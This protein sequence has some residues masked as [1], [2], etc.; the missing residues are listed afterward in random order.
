[1]DYL[2]FIS[3]VEQGMNVL[4]EDNVRAHLHTTVKN[5]GRERR[6][7]TVVKQGVNISPTIY[8]EEFY[9]QYKKGKPLEKIVERLEEFYMEVKMEDSWEGDFVQ[10]Y[11]K[12]RELIVFKLINTAKNRELLKT[13][14]H[15]QY[16]DLSI[17][18]YV[19]L[20]V[21]QG[22]SATMMV[23]DTFLNKWKVGL[24]EIYRQA[25]RNVKV[26]LPATFSGMR[27]VIDA[28]ICEEDAGGMEANPLNVNE[29]MTDD[30]MYV[31]S[32]RLRSFGAAA[33]AYEHI[34]E[35]IGVKLEENFY[36]L[37]SSVHELIILPDSR[38]LIREELDEMIAEI[39]A[40][41]V[42]AEE[43]L[44]N[45]AYYYDRKTKKLTY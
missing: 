28:M 12:I 29:E 9:E 17:V 38:S 37:P 2:E 26:L 25:Q 18:F 42:E 4:L 44:S 20:E 11:E 35:M 36:V 6:G 31:L 23:T 1:M 24:Q 40:T 45:H 15:I 39:N 13:V 34:L 5:N 14:P 41:Q 33:M 22:G 30:N 7:I 10:D 3:A 16:E 8:L 21:Y 19:L 32:N 43:V 27:Q